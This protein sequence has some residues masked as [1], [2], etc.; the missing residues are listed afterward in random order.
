[1]YVYNCS[2]DRT[3]VSSCTCRAL[4]FIVF[5][6]IAYDQSLTLA[7]MRLSIFYHFCL[8]YMVDRLMLKYG[9][10]RLALTFEITFTRVNITYIFVVSY[11]TKVPPSKILYCMVLYSPDAY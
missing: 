3:M 2:M 6:H 5:I 7:S 4:V 1:M 9:S 10:L 8:H 11:P